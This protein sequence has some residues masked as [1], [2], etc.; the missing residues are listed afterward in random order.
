MVKR[1]I[2]Q[3]SEKM[4]DDIETIAKRLSVSKSFVV[5]HAIDRYLKND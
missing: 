1:F 2:F 4:N 3:I 5:K